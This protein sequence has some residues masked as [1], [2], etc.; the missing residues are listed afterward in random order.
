MGVERK[1]KR[2]SLAEFAASQQPNDLKNQVLLLN[3]I[4]DALP[5][6]W[7]RRAV[8]FRPTIAEM[9]GLCGEILATTRNAA[10]EAERAIISATRK[11]ENEAECERQRRERFVVKA[12]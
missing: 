9:R 6:C 5:Q 2:V 10:F 3:M 1:Y 12:A 8:K 7:L 11:A 4:L